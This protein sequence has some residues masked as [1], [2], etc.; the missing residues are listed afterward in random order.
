EEVSER[1]R[2]RLDP[3]PWVV[4][5]PSSDPADAAAEVAAFALGLSGKRRAARRGGRV[6]RLLLHFALAATLA[7]ASV[8][9]ACE[10]PN[11][12]PEETATALQ[13]LAPVNASEA[14]I[15]APAR[16]GPAR[17]TDLLLL[18]AGSD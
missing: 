10:K 15:T 12:S 14:T 13:Q 1:A 6:S 4:P 9:A 17:F 11:A 2:R 16:A 7:L 18:D 5:E 3:Q 8:A